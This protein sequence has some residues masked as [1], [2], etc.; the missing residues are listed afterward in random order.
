VFIFDWKPGSP[1]NRPGITQQMHCYAAYTMHVW[2]AREEDIRLVPVWLQTGE[3]QVRRVSPAAMEGVR[4]MVVERHRM[5]VEALATARGPKA[6]D[7]FPMAANPTPCRRCTF[8]SC[9]GYSR[10]P[11][12]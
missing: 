6:L 2:N 3:A 11:Q 1:V 9:E 7:M 12:R 8:R 10:E 4:T 5:L